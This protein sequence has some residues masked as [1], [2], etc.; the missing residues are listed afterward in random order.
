MKLV[1]TRTFAKFV[2]QV[3]MLKIPEILNV[4]F[5]SRGATCALIKTTT[6]H[7]ITLR[8]RS[9]WSVVKMNISLLRVKNLVKVVRAILSLKIPKHPIYIT[10]GHNATKRVPY[11]RVL[12]VR[13]D[14]YRRM[15]KKVNVNHAQKVLFHLRIV[16]FSVQEENRI[17][18]KSKH[19]AFVA[20]IK[21]LLHPYMYVLFLDPL[22]IL[23]LPLPQHHPFPMR[24]IFF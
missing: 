19:H 4:N 8:K 17:H 3:S 12:M 11:H 9:V 16:A 6:V 2:Q 22:L 21:A 15:E 14:P 1:Q 5:A 13:V 20:A 23:P 24:L 7:Q 18:P 10:T